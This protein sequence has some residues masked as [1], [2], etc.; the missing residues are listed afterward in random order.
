MTSVELAEYF[1]AERQGGFVLVALALLSFGFAAF[2]W[3]ARSAFLAMAW[4][5]VILG[6]FQLVIGLAVALRTPGRV[7]SL[8]Q[9]L[10]VSPAATVSAET[11]RMGRVNRNFR[12]VKV[13]EVVVIVAGLLLVMLL[14]HPGTWAAVGLGL[15]VEAAVL[16]VFDAFAHHRALVYT[17]WLQSA[18]T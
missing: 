8:Q 14:A 6:A 9:G 3:F 10:R 17:Q 5:L 18:G 16:L 15:L 11:Q 2:L 12:I 13:V 7:A 4:P 1:A